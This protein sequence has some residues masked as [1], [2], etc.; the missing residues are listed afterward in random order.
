VKSQPL[1]NRR[2]AAVGHPLT[3]SCIHAA[4]AVFVILKTGRPTRVARYERALPLIIDP[5]PDRSADNNRTTSRAGKKC[6]D[7]LN[8]QTFKRRSRDPVAHQE[9]LRLVTWSD[10]DRGRVT[11]MVGS[12]A[13]MVGAHIGS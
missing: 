9:G 11:V 10:P 6:A 3:A 2:L 4:S 5:C 8:P 13:Q 1:R 12:W 7:S